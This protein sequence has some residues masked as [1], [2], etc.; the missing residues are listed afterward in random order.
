[1][2]MLVASDE[3]HIINTSSVNGFWAGFGPNRAH[4][5]YSAAKFAVKGFTEALIVDLR[6]NAPHVKVS[7]VMPGHIGTS[8]IENSQHLL[9]NRSI[10]DMSAQNLEPLRASLRSQGVPVETLGDEALRAGM[11]RFAEDF[12]DE[13]PMSG[14]CARRCNRGRCPRAKASS[15]QSRRQA[16]ALAY[17]ARSRS[18]RVLGIHGAFL[19][20][21][22]NAAFS[23]I[24]SRA[25]A[26]DP[27]WPKEWV[28]MVRGYRRGGS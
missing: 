25:R 27:A 14:S 17:G 1:M 9:H 18:G 22:K 24:Q 23:D 7:L 4:T 15:A 11:K 5:A 10:E 19:R 13:A 16:L 6:L 8:I 3:G 2:P 21:S 20:V 28:C 12:R 26:G